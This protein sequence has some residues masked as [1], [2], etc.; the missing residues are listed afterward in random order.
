MTGKGDTA[1]PKFV[2]NDEYA[3]RYARTFSRVIDDPSG[4]DD[5]PHYCPPSKA[6]LADSLPPG[7]PDTAPYPYPLMRLRIA[8]ARTLHRI[9]R[10]VAPV[11]L[12]TACAESHELIIDGTA[13]W[14]ANVGPVQYDPYIKADMIV[15]DVFADYGTGRQVIKLPNNGL[16]CWHVSL[17][18]P[19]PAAATLR[20]TY[21]VKRGIFGTDTKSD[22]TIDYPRHNIPTIADCTDTY[23]P[24]R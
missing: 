12:L 24:T 8:L 1:R 23:S 9:A 6:W 22:Q 18:W 16:I 3:E 4:Y 11:L 2:S 15:G 10:W 21:R 5:R 14:Y 19:F 13:P 7:I 20:A 17:D